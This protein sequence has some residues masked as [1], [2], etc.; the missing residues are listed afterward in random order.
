MTRTHLV[1][2]K[3]VRVTTLEKIF[4]IFGMSIR[5]KFQLFRLGVK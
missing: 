3:E 1:D 2:G 4:N 5:L